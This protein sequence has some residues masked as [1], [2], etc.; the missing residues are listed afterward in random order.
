AA[1]A[2]ALEGGRAGPADALALAP[3]DLALWEPDYGRKAEAQVRW[4]AEHGRALPA[5]APGTVVA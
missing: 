2:L 5:D 4:E 3:V 1:F